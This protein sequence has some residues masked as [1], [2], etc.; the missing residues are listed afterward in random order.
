MKISC[1][2]ANKPWAVNIGVMLTAY[3][4]VIVSSRAI[5]KG[6]KITA[7]MVV[8][9]ER[10]VTRLH[11]G[12]FKSQKNVV[13][14]IARFSLGGNRVLQPGNVLPP[15]LVSKGEK[16]VINAATQGLEIRASGIALSDGALGELVRVKNV[17]TKRIIEG[18]VSG[19]GRITVSL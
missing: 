3:D 18:R 16:V 6:S 15:T 12:Y 10:N 2:E 9:E 4:T 13:G 1:D 14:S 17:Q 8:K 7:D 11:R 5:P 19:A